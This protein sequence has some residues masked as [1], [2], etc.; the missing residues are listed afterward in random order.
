M[1]EQVVQDVKATVSQAVEPLESGIMKFNETFH[2]T[3]QFWSGKQQE[4]IT[5]EDV[6]VVTGPDGS[7]KVRRE[8]ETVQVLSNPAVDGNSESCISKTTE[9]SCS[10]S[11]ETTSHIHSHS[12]SSF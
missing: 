11:T 4:T 9:I 5:K 6:T 12:V 1:V 3:I 7:T 10:C 2:E 8:Q